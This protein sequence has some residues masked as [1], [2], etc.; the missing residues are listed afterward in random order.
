LPSPD[1]VGGG[2][3][4]VVGVMWILLWPIVWRIYCE[5]LNVIFSINDT[6]TEVK[7]LLKKKTTT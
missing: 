5:L 2:G 7:N 3:T 6:L 4:V 1:D